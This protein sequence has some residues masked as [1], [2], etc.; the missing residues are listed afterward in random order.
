MLD[1]V[2]LS[3]IVLFFLAGVALVAICQSL[4]RQ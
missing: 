3:L 1:L 2:L 4:M